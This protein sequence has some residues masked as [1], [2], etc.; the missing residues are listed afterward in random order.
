MNDHVMAANGAALRARLS[1]SLACSIV[2][3]AVFSA[4]Q[5][6]SVSH[7]APGTISVRSRKQG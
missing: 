4:Q 3:Y 7:P 1:K 5:G 2:P 6:G